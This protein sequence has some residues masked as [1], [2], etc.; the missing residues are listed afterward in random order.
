MANLATSG[1]QAVRDA[2]ELTRHLAEPR[3]LI[4]WIDFLSSEVIGCTALFLCA[5]SE[6][7][8][9]AVFFV[10]AV[11][12]FYRAVVFIHEVIHLRARCMRPFQAGWNML[13]GI[14]LL[15][16]SFLYGIHLHHHARNLYGTAEDAEYMPWGVRPPQHMLFFPLVSSVAPGLAVLRFLVLT[17]LSWMVPRVRQWV[18]ERASTLVV[19][20][21]YRRHEWAREEY[22]WWRWQELA[23]CAWTWLVTVAVATGWLSLSWVLLVL[24]AVA[25]VALLN[26]I[27]T[28]AAHRYRSDNQAV[29]SIG[30]V[31]DSV[32]HPDGV[33]AELWAPTGLRYHALHHMLPSLPYHALPSAHRILMDKLPSHSFY[34]QTNS[35]G[36]FRTLR[37]LWAD[38]RKSR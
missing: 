30:Q 17:P 10:V 28:L 34:R 19:R 36:L 37:T 3:P 1:T 23:T 9:R 12:G 22:S 18:D 21:K 14:P 35:T 2:F 38:S 5:R 31:Q 33:L 26:S 20:L 24:S 16:P 7:P 27:R 13:L 6:W 32:N 4:F 8:W 15:T 29:T 25:A 11:L